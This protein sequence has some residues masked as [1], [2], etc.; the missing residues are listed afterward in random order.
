VSAF[1]FDD[2]DRLDLGHLSLLGSE[3]FTQEQLIATTER[4]PD[5]RIYFKLPVDF[6][7]TVAGEPTRGPDLFLKRPQVSFYPQIREEAADAPPDIPGVFDREDFV[8]EVAHNLRREAKALELIAQH[9]PHP[10]IVKYHGCRVRRGFVTGVVTEA[11]NGSDLAEYLQAGNKLANK[12]RFLAALESAVRHL[13]N[14]VGIAHNDI[15]PKNIMVRRSDGMP[16]LID[17]GSAH[18]LGDIPWRWTMSTPRWEGFDPAT[19]RYSTASHDTFGLNKLRDWL[20]NPDFPPRGGF[21]QGLKVMN[22]L[23]QVAHG[24]DVASPPMPA[25]PDPGETIAAKRPAER[26]AEKKAER[27]AKR[28]SERIAKK[29]RVD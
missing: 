8:R 3:P 4:V 14:V 19:H 10:H 6:A 12:E 28:R 16:V 13:H 15:K 22:N 21:E 24:G 23:K 7:V 25:A 9:P 11:V 18:P 1:T 5:E 20:D 2:E 26:K 17:F 27:T 29:R